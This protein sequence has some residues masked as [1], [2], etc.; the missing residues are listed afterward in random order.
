MQVFDIDI[1]GHCDFED[2]LMPAMP[3]GIAVAIGELIVWLWDK[4]KDSGLAE[5][6][7]E[8]MESDWY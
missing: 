1:Y 6:E 3:Y 5:E 2:F 4:R 7:A 8:D